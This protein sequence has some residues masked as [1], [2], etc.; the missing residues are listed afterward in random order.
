MQKILHDWSDGDCI[1][2]LKNCR[3]AIKDSKGKVIIVEAV[4]HEEEEE[5]AA[6]EEEDDRWRDVR[7]GLDMAMMAH[8]K[9]GKERTQ[10]EW[11]YVLS[12]AGFPQFTV[13]PT[14]Y[15][16]SVIEAFPPC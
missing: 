4:I 2:I 5:A 1:R 7:L 8:T 10:K 6:A 11:A 14:R 9:E 15:V 13:K 12:R 3:E 16:H